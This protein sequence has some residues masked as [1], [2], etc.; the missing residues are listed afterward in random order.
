MRLVRRYIAACRGHRQAHFL[1]TSEFQMSTMQ[2]GVILL[3][4]FEPFGGDRRN[5][6]IEL[7]REL[8]GETIGGFDVVVAQLPC[9]F[10]RAGMVLTTAVDRCSPRLVLAM[11][12]AAGRAELSFER[13]AINLI[14][15]R[16]PDNA[17]AQPIDEAVCRDA[18]AA[19]FSTLPIKRMV[20]AVRRAGVAASISHSAGTFVCN[21]VFFQLQFH[22][23][24]RTVAVPSGFLHLPLLPEQAAER[25]EA[26]PSL[27]LAEMVTG[28]R[29]ALVEAV[30]APRAAAA[31]A[32]P[33][34]GT[35][36]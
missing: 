13:I 10:A 19:F 2:P 33:S 31:V 11:G 15:A 8:D 4:G 32:A 26:A 36:A 28:L 1:L 5:P 14:D 16:I 18:P 27:S 25:A 17:G 30:A 34:E 20:A 29:A 22:L 12:L 7:A 9:D 6:S 35:V 21:Q 24:G 23:A 3:T